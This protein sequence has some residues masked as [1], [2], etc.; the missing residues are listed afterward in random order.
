MGIL[1]GILG[2]LISPIKDIVSE[3]VVDKD[4]ARELNVRLQELADKADERVHEQMMGQIEVNK[5]EAQH[6]SMFVAGWRPFIGWTGGVGIAYTFVLA[7]FIEF[8]A[9]G[10]FG[11]VQDMPMPDTGQLMT[12]V[13]AMLGVGA[14]RSYDKTQGTARDSLSAPTLIPVDTKTGRAEVAEA[15]APPA[16]RK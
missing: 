7:P 6:A 16:K 3:V 4:K 15:P 11:Y 5:A 14:M 8:I 1:G 12:L 2:D 13:L 10:V 9:R